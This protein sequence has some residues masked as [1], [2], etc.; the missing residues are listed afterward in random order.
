MG[1]GVILD[2]NGFTVE[3]QQPSEDVFEV[4]V[5]ASLDVRARVTM[6]CG[7]PTEPG[8]MWDSSGYEIVARLV[9]GIEIVA[10]SPFE[11]SGT[12]S[13]YTASIST[14]APGEYELQVLASDP[15]KGNFGIAV[16]TVTAR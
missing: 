5:G 15:A 7:C 12:T 8:G 11:F 3:I 2:L 4:E 1:E 9:R 16:R 10:E 14:E 6:L 13:E